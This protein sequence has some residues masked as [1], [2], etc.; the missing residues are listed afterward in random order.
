MSIACG[1]DM[2][3]N[4]FRLLVAEVEDGRLR[5]LAHDLVTVRLGEGL[6][7][8]G[9]LVPAAMLRAEAALS[10]FAALMAPYP[11]RRVR[12][13]ATHAVR[14][15]ANG[16]EFLQRGKALLG[17]RI[18]VLSG[19]EEARL[20][21]RGTLSAL[22][23]QQR[24]YPLLLADVGGGSSEIILQA[25]AESEPRLRSLPLG[26]VGLTEE[27]A[28]DLPAMRKKIRAILAPALLAIL[29][30][31]QRGHVSLFMASGG[32]ATA[33]AALALGLERYDAQRVQNHQLSQ[34][35]VSRLATGLAALSPEERNGLP[36]LED[37]RG[38]IILAGAVIVQELQQELARPV[39]VSDAGLLEGVL[40]SAASGG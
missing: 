20:A 30:G 7:V 16:E 39:L 40:L 38:A 33:L 11:V 14:K 9:L 24:R 10:R 4:S 25:T 1:I 12:A 31:E 29:G 34:I 15:A 37:G 19:E 21:M 36:G 23:S 22:P 35:A 8:S 27:F 3:T 32:T 6:G 5:P 2:G 17:V 28:G 26:A 18:E 13:C